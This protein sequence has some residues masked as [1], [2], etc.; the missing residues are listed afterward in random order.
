MTVVHP[1]RV[2]GPAVPYTVPVVP[3]IA[4]DPR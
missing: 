4:K 1:Y 3:E 2:A